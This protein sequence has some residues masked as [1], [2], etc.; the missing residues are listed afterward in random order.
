[1]SQHRAWIIRE[2]EA[3][4]HVLVEFELTKLKNWGELRP[5][6]EREG[7]TVEA[8]NRE[9]GI[10]VFLKAGKA[11][12]SIA[13]CVWRLNVIEFLIRKNLLRGLS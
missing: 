10:G 2:G 12:S 3:L 1:M 6:E 8:Q 7:I 11:I 4:K 13:Y 9:T 5:V